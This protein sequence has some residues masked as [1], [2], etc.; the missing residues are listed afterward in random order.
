MSDLLRHY[1]EMGY[2]RGRADALDGRPY[3]ARLPD[4]RE[5]EDNASTPQVHPPSS[6]SSS[7]QASRPDAS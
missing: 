7:E 2:F 5:A 6:V 1:Y 4:E 3:D